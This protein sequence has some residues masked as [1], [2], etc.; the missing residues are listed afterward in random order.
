MN[1]KETYK[2]KANDFIKEGE[3]YFYLYIPG[4]KLKPS[5]L[6]KKKL[7]ITVTHIERVD[8]ER[9]LVSFHIQFNE[10]NRFMNYNVVIYDERVRGDYA[11]LE[12]SYHSMIVKYDK[13]ALKKALMKLAYL[14]LYKTI[15][16][17]SAEKKEK[18]CYNV[19]YILKEIKKVKL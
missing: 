2:G 10:V 8:Q 15:N 19:K 13:L 17:L 3:K 4:I 18:F 5:D 14:N 1:E 16:Q 12:G 7:K 6:Y 9:G 11:F